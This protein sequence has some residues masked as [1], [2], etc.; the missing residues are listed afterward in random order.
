[1]RLFIV[2][3]TTFRPIDGINDAYRNKYWDI[4][5]NNISQSTFHHQ[6]FNNHPWLSSLKECKE[7]DPDER[8]NRPTTDR[9]S[10]LKTNSNRSN[11]MKFE[12][13]TTKVLARNHRVNVVLKMWCKNGTRHS[14]PRHY[15]ER[16]RARVSGG[17]HAR[18]I[19]ITSKLIS[20][21]YR[22]TYR[23]QTIIFDVPSI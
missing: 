10:L 14:L 13:I 6:T 12:K 16:H 7:Q 17:L 2:I 15:H 23:C 8:M 19:V 21:R 5:W 11:T 9:R 1:M 3:W 20:C 22:H 4:Y 18:L